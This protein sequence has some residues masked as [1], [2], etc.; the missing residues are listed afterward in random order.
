MDGYGQHCGSVKYY[1]SL[2]FKLHNSELFV[3]QVCVSNFN[4]SKEAADN[5]KKTAFENEKK[6][7]NFNLFEKF[8]YPCC[9]SIKAKAL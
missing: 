7:H 4:A 3:L 2:S 8:I 6:K 5:E 9:T 1:G